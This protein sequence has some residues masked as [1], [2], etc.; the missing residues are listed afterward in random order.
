MCRHVMTSW[1]RVHP[2]KCADSQHN[3]TGG[4]V[5]WGFTSFMPL[6]D[7]LDPRKGFLVDDTITVS[8]D[9]LMLGAPHLQQIL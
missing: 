8:P 2:F 3:F 9:A 6:R 4:A 7:L 1:Y 5:D